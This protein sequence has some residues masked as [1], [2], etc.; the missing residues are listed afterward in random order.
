[1]YSILFFLVGYI[2][3]FV[4]IFLFLLISTLDNP[5]LCFYYILTARLPKVKKRIMKINTKERVEELIEKNKAFSCSGL[6]LY[7]G[8]MV[9]N[10]EDVLEAQKRVIQSRDQQKQK[11]VNKANDV[12]YKKN[13]ML[14]ILIN[15]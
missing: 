6:H 13:K 10:S 14:Y 8:T 5:L 11:S 4:Y 12:A 15:C 1:M 9:A 7:M 2:I 3:C